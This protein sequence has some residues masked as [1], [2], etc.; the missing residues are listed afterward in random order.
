MRSILLSDSAGASLWDFLPLTLF[1]IGIGA[2]V[3]VFRWWA[4]K[5]RK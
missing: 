2:A 4:L 3:Y 1:F 5:E